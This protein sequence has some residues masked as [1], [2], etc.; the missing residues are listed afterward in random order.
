LC[1]CLLLRT[2]LFFRR[3]SIEDSRPPPISDRSEFFPPASPSL[4][5][6]SSSL[7]S[8]ASLAGPSRIRKILARPRRPSRPFGPSVRPGSDL[9]LTVAR[10]FF[11]Y[12]RSLQIP[13]SD[14]P[15]PNTLRVRCSRS[16][17][18]SLLVAAR[19]RTR[20]FSFF[21]LFFSRTVRAALPISSLSLLIARESVLPTPCKR[22]VFSVSSS[23]TMTAQFSFFPS[24]PPPFFLRYFIKFFLYL[25]FQCISF[26]FLFP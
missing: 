6:L 19:A 20:S 13:R 17:R 21:H 2:S 16:A 1:V 15:C 9:P 4:L 3:H 10:G 8:A 22:S 14:L 24:L 26:S 5:L 25:R 7:F 12:Q 11:F 23:T 18:Y